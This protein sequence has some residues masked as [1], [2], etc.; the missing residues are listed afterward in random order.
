MRST[1]DIRTRGNQIKI[2]AKW[3]D[4]PTKGSYFEKV[5]KYFVEHNIA[6]NIVSI[7]FITSGYA[8]SVARVIY[9]QPEM[10]K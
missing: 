10:K 3:D 9:N 5:E 4:L 6:H 7:D 8:Y 2:G 1:V